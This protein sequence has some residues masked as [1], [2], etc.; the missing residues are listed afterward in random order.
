VAADRRVRRDG[1]LAERKN[2]RLHPY[3]AEVC[4]A[5]SGYI[6]FDG[7]IPIAEMV[8]REYRLAIG[9]TVSEKVPSRAVTVPVAV[10]SINTV[11]PGISPPV[12]ASTGHGHGQRRRPERALG[13]RTE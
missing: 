7:L 9:E 3:L 13:V 6:H 12:A 1:H 8:Q 10:P 2:I 11:S 4:L 5:R